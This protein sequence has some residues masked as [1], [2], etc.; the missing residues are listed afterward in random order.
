MR[1][2]LI[3][4]H[5]DDVSSSSPSWLDIEQLAQ[6][7]ITSEDPA[8]PIESALLPSTPPVARRP[9]WRAGDPARV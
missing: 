7:E 3:H 8:Y 4:H 1:K 6:V 2:Q 5:R 9:P